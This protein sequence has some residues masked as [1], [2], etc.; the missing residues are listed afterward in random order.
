MKIICCR[1]VSLLVFDYI[2]NS[3][4]VLQKFLA[5]RLS[6]LSLIRRTVKTPVQ[7]PGSN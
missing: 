1:S 3:K 7:Q 5:V 2:F 4:K 6:K